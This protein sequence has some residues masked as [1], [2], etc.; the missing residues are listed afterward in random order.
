MLPRNPLSKRSLLVAALSVSLLAPLAWAAAPSP[1]GP[2]APQGLAASAGPGAGEITLSWGPATSLLGVTS[3]SVYRVAPDGTLSPA[4][5]TNA[6]TLSFA[7]AG[8][9]N[10]ATFTYV[11]TATDPT[12][13]GPASDPASATT[14][15][16]PSAPQDVQA[17]PGPAGSVGDVALSWS[18]P[19]NDGGMPVVSFDVYRDGAL[20]ATLDGAATSWTD[21][22]LTPLSDHRYAVSA[23]TGVGEGP[24]SDPSCSM[25]S[26]WGL[27]AG[28]PSCLGI[29]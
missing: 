24:A 15:S 20:V 27:G 18:A 7:D 6:S 8:L 22:G 12:G 14:F 25:P 19:A 2:G 16:L 9:P 3:Y 4:G 10:G 21:H 11:V 26:P 1:V 29:A 5:Q 23:V 13:E 28:E 17:A